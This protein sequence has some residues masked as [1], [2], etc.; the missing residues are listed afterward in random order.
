MQERAWR[1]IS[2]EAARLAEED[3]EV[4]VRERRVRVEE[5][6]VAREAHRALPDP[7]GDTPST[8]V[9]WRSPSGKRARE[10]GGE[11]GQERGKRRWVE[12]RG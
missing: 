12:E 11:A 1:R 10:E 3:S 2:S 5:Q 6:A 7:E 9:E 8:D 4:A